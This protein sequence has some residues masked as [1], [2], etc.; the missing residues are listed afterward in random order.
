MKIGKFLFGVAIGA[1]AGVLLAPKKGSELREDLKQ[2]SKKAYHKAKNMTKEDIINI[3]NNSITSI[4]ETIEE[5][6]SETFKNST[7]EKLTQLGEQITELKDK[8]VESEEFAYLADTY[9]NITDTIEEKVNDIIYKVKET[10][11]EEIID[12]LEDEIEDITNDI[13]ELIDEMAEDA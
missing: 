6:D 10:D 11:S 3:Y 2:N 8:I 4:K 1:F 9:K 12:E 7:K 13:E 5:F